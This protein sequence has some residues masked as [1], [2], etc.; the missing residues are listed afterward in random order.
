MKKIQ[1]T[2][3]WTL[4][5]G[6]AA[7]LFAEVPQWWTDRN[8]VNTN[9][10]AHDYNPVNQGQVKW[11]CTQAAAEFMEKLPGLGNTNLLNQMAAFP[12]G[13]N[14]RPANQGMLKTVAQPFYTRLIEEGYVLETPWAGKTAKDYAL[15]NQGQLKNLFCFDF[16]QFNFL[17]DSDGDGVSDALELRGTIYQ[18]IPGAFTWE[19]AAVDAERLGGHLATITSEQE[20]NILYQCVGEQAF[21]DNHLWFG[22]S[23]LDGDG[24]WSWI[25]DELFD[26]SRW[27]T[28][29][30]LAGANR[31]AMY[32]RNYTRNNKGQLWYDVGKNNQ[33]G[34]LLEYAAAL[35]PR[36]NDTDGDGV[37]DL[38]EIRAGGNPMLVDTDG[39]G[40][41]DAEEIAAGTSPAQP[42]TDFDGLTDSQ[43]LALG[44]DPVKA[45]TDGDG[46]A[47]G[48]ELCGSVYYPVYGNLQ[49]HDAKVH[50]ESLGGHL[51]TITSE[52]EQNRLVEMVGST[53]MRRYDLWLGASDEALEGDWRWVTGESM[54]YSNW[55]QSGAWTAPNDLNNEDVLL[56][57]RFGGSLWN[58]ASDA[59]WHSYIMEIDAPLDPLN[60]DCDGDGLLDG[61]E[62]ALG[63]NPL[64][65]DSDG[66]GVSDVDEATAGLNGAIADSDLDGL[67]DSEEI[68][69][70]TDPLNS[71]SDGDGLLDGEEQ[72]I[73]LT[74]P[75]AELNASLSL[76]V[77]GVAG[78][79]RE[80]LHYTTEYIEDGDDLIITSLAYDPS[81]T[82]SLT[83]NTAGMYRLALQLAPYS[84]T[85]YQYDCYPVEISINGVVIDEIPAVTDR[86]ELAEGVVY[87]PWLEA[88]VYEIKCCFRRPNILGGNLRI[89]GL[90]LY[91]INGMDSDGD[92]IQ[93]WVEARLNAGLDSDADGLSDREELSLGTSLFLADTDG[94]GLSDKDELTA[95]TDPL[96]ADSDNDGVSDGIEVNEV[97]TD[98]LTA[99]FDGTVIDHLV[100][101]GSQTNS[102]IGSWEV[103]GTEIRSTSRRGA[104]EY[105]V[106]LPEQDLYCFNIN[107]THLWK[108]SGCT[109]VTPIDTSYMQVSVDGLYVGS[110]PLVAADSVYKDIR[111]FL[112]VLPAGEHTVRIFWENTSKNLSLKVRDLRLQEYGGLDANG[113]GIKDWV[114]ASLASSTSID[115]SLQSVVSPICLEGAAR[116]PELAKLYVQP[117]TFNVQRAAGARWYANVPLDEDNEETAIAVSFQNGAWNRIVQAEWV[118]LNLLQSSQTNLM[119]RVGDSVKLTALPEDA[120]GGQFTITATCHSTLATDEV[121]SPNCDPVVYSFDQPGTYAVTGE[122]TKGNETVT[123]ELTVTVAGW[124]FP[125]TVP[126]CLLGSE[127]AWSLLDVPTGTVFDTDNYVS[128]EADEGSLTTNGQQ[129]TQFNLLA[130]GVNGDHIIAARLYEGGPILDTMRIDPFWVQN[131]SDG[132]FWVVER[133]EDSELWEVNSV[134]K[135][136]PESV[137]MQIKIF[138]AGVTLDDYTM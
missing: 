132:Y 109:P 75:L 6:T 113:D 87:T 134:V 99:D 44:T 28:D 25:T 15:A 31:A 68:A 79:D 107:A 83:N 98:A 137:D 67:T 17:A 47:D 5:L 13:S 54:D 49:W 16:D 119:I 21:Y 128:F 18:A 108:S 40:L 96:N 37:N 66:D 14:F 70:G 9:N 58:D 126:A 95:G 20:Q 32:H 52:E 82:W 127:R 123:G 74:N 97:N 88:G 80:I 46:I 115:S 125:E 111:V 116:Y 86:G 90:E 120:N 77:P 124:Q 39:D 42:D 29:R 27:G 43:E 2:I 7:L 45:D 117:S 50:A 38:D 56:S 23:D 114:Q 110:Y 55:I 76:F 84:K 136:L 85:Q 10:V 122:Y 24:Q 12:E 19:E 1:K 72:F 51:A 129:Q 34:Y 41:T 78:Y 94:D 35:N 57:T 130:T 64:S 92:G 62:I 65:L 105:L 26:Y 63:M 61:A 118:P 91:T 36:S 81:V 53:V 22:A 101:T 106:T 131:A 11:M 69:L 93:D 60:P 138:V 133:Y 103:E 104:L 59:L 3:I 8:V 4:F 33:Y 73:T 100:L 30:P 102:V 89:N 121:R 112:P 135:N 48:L 71:D